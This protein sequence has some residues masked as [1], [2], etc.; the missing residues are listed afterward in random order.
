MESVLNIRVRTALLAGTMALCAGAIHGAAEPTVPTPEAVPAGSV[1][2][3]PTLGSRWVLVKDAEHPGG[4]GRLVMEPQ[5]L[6]RG[7]TR[8]R[9]AAPVIRAGDRVL[10]EENTPVARGVLEAIALGSA[11][12]GAAFRVRLTVGGLVVRVIAAGPG[13]AI[14]PGVGEVLP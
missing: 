10:V 2:E 9:A 5:G 3:D 13:R 12:Q 8:E 14:L 7:A 11:R 6:Q 4:P 1:I